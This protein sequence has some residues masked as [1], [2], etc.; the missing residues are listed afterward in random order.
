MKKVHLTLIFAC[1]TLWAH[2]TQRVVT[3]TNNTGAGSL[4]NAVAA[5]A[6]ADTVR[7]DPSLISAGSN[8]INLSSEIIA[9]NNIVIKG[10]YNSADTLYISGQNTSRIFTFYGTNVVLDSLVLVKG[11]ATTNGGG[12]IYLQAFGTTFYLKNSVLKNNS[13]TQ[14][15]GAISFYNGSCYIVNSTLKNNSA[16]SDGGALYYQLGGNLSV[17]NSTMSYNTSNNFGGAICMKGSTTSYCY[18]KKAVLNNN[19]S[20]GDG[21]AV[22]Y[23]GRN[24]E[25]DSTIATYNTA[26]GLY[27]G[28]IQF[29]LRFSIVKIAEYISNST[30]AYN[31][32]VG[33][34]ANVFPNVS[35]DC[36][37]K[38]YVS[39][40]TINDN[41]M[42]G[43]YS[44]AYGDNANSVSMVDLSYSTIANNG[45]ASGI[46]GG[47]Y[48]GASA[49][50]T[51]YAY[52]SN[53]TVKNSTIVGNT[54]SGN[55][56]GIYSL[57]KIA[58]S[59]IVSTKSSIVAFNTG[60]KNILSYATTTGITS[61]GYNLFNEPT[62][63]GSA[64]TD[65]L[66][67][68]AANL[69]LGALG[70]NG[71]FTNTMMPLIGSYAINMGTPSDLTAAQNSAVVGGRREAGAAEYLQCVK[72]RT[73]GLAICQGDSL[74][75][76]G[77]YRKTSGTYKDTVNYGSCDS[78]IT[79]NLAVK[80]K[81]ARTLTLSACNAYTLNAQTY[82]TT[83]VYTQTLTNAA[84]CDST[85]TLNL[86]V[87][88]PT[89]RTITQTS[90]GNY[91]AN[92]QT[93]TTSGVYTQ[94]LTNAAGCDSILTLNLTIKQPTNNTLTQSACSSYA[95][96]SQT[97]TASGVYTQTLTNAAGCDSILTLNLTVKQPTSRTLTQSA[98]NSYTL[99][100]Q[101]YTLS[102][103]Y[104]QTL[105]NAA[106][107]DSIVTLNL[108]IDNINSSVSQSGLVL[109]ANENGASY[110]WIDC[111]N[112]N[113]PVPGAN[114]QSFSVT[115]NGS[116]AVIVTKNACTQTSSCTT[117]STVGMPDLT[118][119]NT[120]NLYPNPNTGIFT[121][122]LNTTDEI[123]LAIYDVLGK[124]IYHETLAGHLHTIDLKGQNAGVYFVKIKLNGSEKVI[125]MIRQ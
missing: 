23:E 32:G 39:Y 68:S 4:R 121:I 93:Y 25:M 42:G 124:E 88:H 49:S 111:N 113:Q 37:T 119:L 87:R 122:E 98:C 104:T 7:F 34:S 65:Q 75:F 19:T 66:G 15:G 58:A 90:C 73:T 112:G 46:A 91:A 85:L 60:G 96:N 1:L 35:T 55:G 71:G 3:N 29:D 33:I 92:S 50:S 78:I 26:G 102:G 114:A 108:T 56:C 80:L 52:N 27:K 115:A 110:Q 125:R 2:A 103:T 95:L 107:C 64:A 16:V 57:G 47:I 51:S 44:Y 6:S 77:I 14:K 89:S 31:T 20:T 8:T 120:V 101:V 36:E 63:L 70:N 97:Y 53:V 72:L 67:V 76:N 45:N 62:V 86:T 21:G 24:F 54:F 40:C 82:T 99:N 74:L 13:T 116:Y 38:M 123:M 10:L 9:N 79:L 83:G 61:L 69:N 100:S 18:L 105:T 11:K 41:T 59:S 117:I 5:S 22:Y 109:T 43:I 48:S 81:T 106:G 17:E 30:I 28:I 12:A 94:T 118:V 84:G